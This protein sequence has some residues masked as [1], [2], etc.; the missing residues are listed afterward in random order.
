RFLR[1][2][3]NPV[4]EP[5]TEFLHGYHWFW[6]AGMVHGLRLRDGKA[7]WF[8]SRFVMDEHAARIR[9]RNPIGGPGV[10]RR[11]GAVNTNTTIVAGK[12]C[13]IVEAGN[14]PV[15]L[16]DE[17]ESVRRTDFG[18]TLEAGFTGHPKVDPITREQHALAY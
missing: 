6:G 7:E 10:G 1:I 15:E 4:D 3:P 8:R 13:A 12:L 2:G 18:G 5:D 11:D 17:L 14:L 16:D 9:G